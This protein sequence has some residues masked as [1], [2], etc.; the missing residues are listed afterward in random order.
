M[1]DTLT[2]L[3]ET[4]GYSVGM[5][6][7]TRGDSNA[8]AMLLVRESNNAAKIVSVRWQMTSEEHTQF[9]DFYNNNTVYGALPF[10]LDLIIDTEELVTYL[11]RWAGTPDITN[12][13]ESYA[14]S[15]RLVAQR[16]Y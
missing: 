7:N 14:V 12:R 9:M 10:Y 13:G 15:G 1:A 6:A 8:A 4:A 3:P 11:C 5:G 2:L 16:E